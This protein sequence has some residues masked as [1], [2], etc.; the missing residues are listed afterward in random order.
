MQLAGASISTGTA[1]WAYLMMVCPKMRI[2]LGYSVSPDQC[3]NIASKLLSVPLPRLGFNQHLPREVVFGPIS[4]GGLAFHDLCVEESV[5][6]L[7][8]FF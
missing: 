5:R 8:Q 7:C 4:T 2:P 3:E 6:D 1:N